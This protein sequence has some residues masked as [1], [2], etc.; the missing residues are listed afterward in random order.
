MTRPIRVLHVVRVMNR[1]GL[2]TWLMRLLRH[3]DRREIAFD[4]LVYGAEP[5]TYDAEIRSLGARIL[6]CSRP[7]EPWRYARNFLRILREQGPYDVVHSHNYFFSGFDLWLAKL[8]GVKKRIAHLHPVRDLES[9]R[10]FRSLYRHCMGTRIRKYADLVLAPSQAS[11]DAFS[12]YT[13]LSSKP[14][15][16][17]H[18]CIDN[19][20]A[21]PVDR[22]A[23]RRQLSLPSDKPVVVYVARFEPHKNH[24]MLIALAE[25]L[26]ATGV[27]A[28]YVAAGTD[29]SARRDFERCVAGRTDFSVMVDC[30]DVAPLLGCA[31]LF[32]FP[33]TEEGF[34]TVA[35]EAAAAGVPVVATDLPGIRE[36]LCP[37][38][39]PYMFAEGDIDSAVRS[40]HSI[41]SDP[42]LA[43]RLREEGR[44]WAGQFSVGTVAAQL[45]TIYR[46]ICGPGQQDYSPRKREARLA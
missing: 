6:Q 28:H 25:R 32:F 2:E 44:I 26:K 23:V 1:A 34:G 43:N 38:Q 19:G 37:A 10:V 21:S 17:V 3:F 8:G 40:V 12:D 9:R 30:V 11:L 31:D 15:L 4:F 5:G 45:S 20:C 13:D 27:K 33:S 18:N 24:A 22:A 36:A 16:V 46:D 42:T 35:I 14:R 41:L 7:R 39:R 29:G